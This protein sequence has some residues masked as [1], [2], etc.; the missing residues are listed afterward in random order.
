M[1]LAGS[2]S[3]G[4]QLYIPKE[5]EEIPQAP[6]TG[7]PVAPVRLG[8]VRARP[9]RLLVGRL[10]VPPQGLRDRQVRRRAGR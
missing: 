4:V 3:D 6:Q 1:N 2:L 9:N 7:V 5:G 8:L 10:R